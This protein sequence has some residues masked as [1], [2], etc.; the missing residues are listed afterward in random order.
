MSEQ[1]TFDL[2]SE[3]ALGRGDFFVSPS[4][5][6]AVEAVQTWHEWPQG[7][8]LL[9]G[10]AGSGKTHLAHVWAAITGARIVAAEHVTAG[11]VEEL[12]AHPIAVEDAHRIA[13]VRAAEEALFH[14]HNLALAERQP[15][16]LTARAPAARWGLGLPDLESRMQGSAMVSLSGPDDMLLGALLVKLFAD[17]Q[18]TPETKVIDYILSRMERSFEG[19]GRLVAALDR[20][21][22]SQKRA[23]TV[24]LA[25]EVLDKMGAEVA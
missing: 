4:N 24:P 12:A 21:A 25:T 1:L 17:R 9:I 2:P 6:A 3:P 13:G 14:L 10:P 11:R 23:I 18:L 19:A 20:A 22:L 5:H 15:L 8:M 7:K 16:L